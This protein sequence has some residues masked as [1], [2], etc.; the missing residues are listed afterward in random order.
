MAT[1]LTDPQAIKDFVTGLAFLGTGGGAGKIE[2]ALE[3]LEPVLKRGQGI[4]LVSPDELPDD[5]WTCAIASWGGRDPD[6]PPSKDELAQ[7]GLIS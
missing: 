2:D 4:T 6:T 5:A 7:Y 1:T 3:M